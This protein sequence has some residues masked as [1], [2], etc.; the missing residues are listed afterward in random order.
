MTL[1]SKIATIEFAYKSNLKMDDQY[2]I[3]NPLGFQVTSYR[4]DSDYAT[5]PPEE[6][7]VAPAA[8]DPNAEPVAQQPAA[9]PEGTMTV[10][11]GAAP[12]ADE[13]LRT[14]PMPQA[15]IPE[16]E[17]PRTTAPAPAAP[18]PARNTANGVGRR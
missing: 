1:D 13:G 14:A 7:P 18:A 15:P 5:A 17:A 9:Q 4:V 8:A 11:P 3:E 12:A 6:S 16:R 10:Q 2:R